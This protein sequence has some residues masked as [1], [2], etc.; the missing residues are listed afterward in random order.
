MCGSYVSFEAA[1]GDVNG[2]MALYA[3]H[4]HVVQQ[5]CGSNVSAKA[6]MRPS[7][8]SHDQVWGPLDVQCGIH[9]KQ[10]DS[11]GK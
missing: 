10:G 6:A 3:H 4:L 1:V 2:Y 11:P 8:W 9:A 5:K 7:Q